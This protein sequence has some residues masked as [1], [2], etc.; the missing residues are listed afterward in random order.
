[1]K[2]KNEIQKDGLGAAKPPLEVWPCSTPW[3]TAL[4]L[5]LQPPPDA[6]SQAAPPWCCRGCGGV[7]VPP[8]MQ[9]FCGGRRGEEGALADPPAILGAG[10]R[11]RAAVALL[12]HPRTRL[13]ILVPYWW[14]RR[15][16]RRKRSD[17]GRMFGS[18]LSRDS[19]CVALLGS[20]LES[21]FA[22]QNTV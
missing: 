14:V 13:A 17:A 10:H 2:G 3:G 11:G 21:I 8:R 19:K 4:S 22:T 5:P 12:R 1:M 9:P 15:L 6:S 20:L 16:W 18:L 7:A